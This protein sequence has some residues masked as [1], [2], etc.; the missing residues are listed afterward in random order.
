MEGKE[1]TRTHI[2]PNGAYMGKKSSKKMLNLAMILQKMNEFFCLLVYFFLSSLCIDFN[3]FKSSRREKVRRLPVELPSNSLIYFAFKYLCLC[4][5]SLD[6][7]IPHISQALSH[8]PFLFTEKFSISL[9]DEDAFFPPCFFLS[10]AASLLT[11]Y[12]M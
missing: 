10:F 12:G 2:R 11:L 6:F 3:S 4:T 1:H 8:Q 9:A 7:S 5:F